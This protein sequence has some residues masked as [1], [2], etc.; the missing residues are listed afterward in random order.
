MALTADLGSKEDLLDLVDPRL[1]R[2]FFVL[3]GALLK[4]GR[5]GPCHDKHQQ[6]RHQRPAIH[7]G[8]PSRTVAVMNQSVSFGTKWKFIWPPCP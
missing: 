1:F 6:A 8:S 4:E 7:V 3:S 5:P 2:G